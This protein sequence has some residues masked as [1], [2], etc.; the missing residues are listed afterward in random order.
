[1]IAL[2]V[3]FLLLFI[4]FLKLSH[5]QWQRAQ[6]KIEQIACYQA[7]RQRPPLT[8]QD[9]PD[10]A[11]TPEKFRYHPI[12]LQGTLD[13]AHHILLDNQIEAGQ[14]GY[15]LLTPLINQD[16]NYAILI[17]QGWLPRGNHRDVLP[18]LPTL[19]VPLSLTGYLDQRSN[20]RFIQQTI[21]APDHRW[22]LR[23]QQLTWTVIESKLGQPLLPLYVQIESN[24]YPALSKPRIGGLSPQRHQ[25]Y[26]VQWLALAITVAII[27]LLMLKRQLRG[28]R[29]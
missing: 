22:P 18:Q 17:D 27:Y 6:T 3:P 2:S 23:V 12:Q 28:P 24:E 9:L 4:L 11:L 1:M 13:N 20:N 5:W 8:Q 19:N 29:I 15:R 7:Q 10:I 21:E 25:G 26:A 16:N 14:V